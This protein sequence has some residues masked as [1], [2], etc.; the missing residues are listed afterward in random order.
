MPKERVL[1]DARRYFVAIKRIYKEFIGA[2][3]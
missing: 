2:K 1:F 3:N